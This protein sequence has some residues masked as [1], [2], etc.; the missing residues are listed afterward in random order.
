MVSSDSKRILAILIITL[1]IISVPVLLF[2]LAFTVYLTFTEFVQYF[3]TGATVNGLMAIL[4]VVFN[5]CLF[6]A[7]WA[8]IKWLR[9]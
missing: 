1:S 6:F 4:L 8:L 2:F 9:K 5:V 7:I 3:Q